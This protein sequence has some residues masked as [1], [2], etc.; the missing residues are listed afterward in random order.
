M[1][2]DDST[3][4]CADKFGDV[5]ALPL[6]P[7]PE[8]EQKWRDEQ[9]KAAAEPV[10]EAPYVPSA[11]VFTV[12]SGHN[13]KVLEEQMK[14]TKRPKKAK[15]GPTFKH[16]LLFGHVSMLTDIVY[17]TANG[18]SYI[19]TADRDEH[20]RVSRGTVEQAHIIE[21]FCHGHDAFVSR[22]CLAGPELLVSGGGD[23]YLC[24][25]DWQNYRLLEKLQIRDAVWQYMRSQP[26]LASTLPEDQESF[27]TA[28]SGLWSVPSGQP[29]VLCNPTV[30]RTE[31]TLSR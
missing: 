4:L 17:A 10:T 2:S 15:E 14:E 7:T 9:A 18:R 6:M 3:I 24:V 1:T 25:W 23:P 27:R 5:Y 26:D 21:G 11:S 19:I 13:R 22:L 8:E 12:H 28:V 30:H 31:L 16:E 20:I 29:Q